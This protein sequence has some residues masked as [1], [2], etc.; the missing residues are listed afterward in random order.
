MVILS[1]KILFATF[2]ISMIASP[3]FATK[4]NKRKIAQVKKAIALKEQQTL[5]QPKLAPVQALNQSM[6][7]NKPKS[8]W[9]KIEDWGIKHT[10][11]AVVG[12]AL[13][14]GL[15]AGLYAGQK[16]PG[17]FPIKLASFAA[18]TAGATI[19]SGL[20]IGVTWLCLFYRGM[21]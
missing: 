18:A 16:T 15:A 3:L 2:A 17:P 10:E 21:E 1:K 4:E 5:Q 20:V 14:L 6:P 19:A 7:L 13:S 11:K 12:S 8:T 9:K